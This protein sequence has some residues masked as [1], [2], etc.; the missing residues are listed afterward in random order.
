MHFGIRPV[1]CDASADG[2]ISPAMIKQAITP[3]TKAVVITH[4]WGLPCNIPKITSILKNMPHIL[5]LEDCSHA[6]GAS[7]QG[8]MAGTFGDGAAWSLQGQKI[9]SGGEGGIVLTKHADF[10]YRQLIWG[11]YNKRCKSEIPQGHFLRDFALTGTGLKTRAHPLAIAIARNQLRK[12]KEFQRIKNTFA[13]RLSDELVGIP[14]LEPVQSHALRKAGIQHAW[15]AFTFRFKK[16]RAPSGLTRSIFVQEL[17]DRG[18][19]D[20]DIPNSIRLL[21]GEPLY[22][23]PK[24]ILPHVAFPAPPEDW[25]VSSHKYCGAKAFHDEVVKL[26]VWAIEDE[27]VIVNFYVDNIQAVARRWM[28]QT[29]L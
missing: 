8:Q 29:K 1:F 5:L 11:H 23:R 27:A 7:I 25:K 21:H 2:N 18:L 4:M 22:T 12:L 17:L 20:I 15:Y 28:V 6:I 19:K 16:D 26:P 14:F 10:H 3:R 9:V 13:D 24:E